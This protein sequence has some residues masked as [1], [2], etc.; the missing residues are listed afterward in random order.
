[1]VILESKGNLVILQLLEMGHGFS[2]I[3]KSYSVYGSLCVVFGEVVLAECSG[4][5]YFMEKGCGSGVW[6]L[7]LYRGL[8]FLMLYRGLIGSAFGRVL[9]TGGILYIVLLA[10]KWAMVCLLNFGMIFGAGNLL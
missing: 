3:N 1:M 2:F 4:E 8:W 5:Q 6:F 10:L 9:R 7:M